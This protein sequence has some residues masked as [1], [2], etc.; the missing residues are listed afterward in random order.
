LGRIAGDIEPEELESGEDEWETEEELDDA[1]T[2]VRQSGTENELKE[3]HLQAL[4][5]EPMSF[6]GGESCC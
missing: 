2:S 6:C 5:V 4:A 1:A 3:I